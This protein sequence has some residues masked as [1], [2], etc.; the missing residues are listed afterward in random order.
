[1]LKRKKINLLAAVLLTGSLMATACSKDAAPSN[2]PSPSSA[3]TASGPP[4]KTPFTFTMN[5]DNPKINWNNEVAQEITKRTGATIKW[6]VITG[7]FRTKMNVWLAA[8]DYPE[9]INIHDNTLQSYITAK[10]VLDLTPLIK[11]HA[12]NI[13]KAF[14][15]DLSILQ[16]PDG[17]I[18]GLLQPPTKKV[19]NL[20]QAG[21]I[22]IQSAVL[23]DAGY[24]PIKTLDDVRNLV[25]NYMKKYPEIGGGKTIGFS[26][27]G[28]ANQLYNVFDTAAR[29]Y[30]GL[31]TTAQYFVDDQNNARLRFFEPGYTDLFKFFNKVN[32]EGLFDPESLVQTQEQF[33]TKCNQGRVLVIFGGGGNCNGSLEK[34]N[35]VDRTYVSFD[36]VAPGKT[37]LIVKPSTN[38]SRGGDMWLSIT[39]NAKDPVRIIQFYDDMYKLENQILVGWGIEGKYYKVEN[40]KRVVTDWLVNEYKNKPDTFWEDLGMG[41]ARP[42]STNYASGFTLSDGD[43]AMWQSSQ[44]WISKNM[45]AVSVETL[46]KYGAKTPADLLVKG[47]EKDYGFAESTIKWTDDIKKFNTEAIAEWGKALPKFILEKD[48]SKLD[49]IWA[50][51]E[52]TLKAKGL[53]KQNKDVTDIYQETLKTLKK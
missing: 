16:Q 52:K 21:W 12:P 44:S 42:L 26:N 11:E 49:G 27:Y 19:E 38:P 41:Y 46:A 36:I 13:M 34:N 28:A 51:L 18:Y 3:P 15:N 45:N 25:A 14:N 39:K 17:K 30:A 6:D 24:P 50:D 20:N 40:G 47:T 22:A 53:D 29:S 10:A 5:T 23:K 32:A 8:N 48:A 7:D 9:V 35:M 37:K 4:A 31:P 43:Y 1:M 2:S 33:T